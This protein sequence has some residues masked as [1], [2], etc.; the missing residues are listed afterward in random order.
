M[1]VRHSSLWQEIAGFADLPGSLV[2]YD[3][4]TKLIEAVGRSLHGEP[5]RAQ[6]RP[7]EGGPPPP[8]WVECA[9]R[10]VRQI[11]ASLM[12]GARQAWYERELVLASLTGGEATQ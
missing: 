9:D 10:I 4:D 11:E 3:C 2:C 7:P 1:I 5:P 8:G 12:P 6:P